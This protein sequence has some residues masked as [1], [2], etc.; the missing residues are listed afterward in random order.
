MDW[1]A[2]L[3][4]DGQLRIDDQQSYKSWLKTLKP[5]CL[6]VTIRNQRK[7]RSLPQ[8]NLHWLRCEYLA[9]YS[10]YSKE[11]IHELLMHACNYHDKLYIDGQEHHVRWTST[12]LSTVQFSELFK[13]QQALA[14]WLSGDGEPLILPDPENYPC[15]HDAKRR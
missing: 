3:S 13:K 5:G 1:L 9:D 10:G 8:N 14:D 2:T 15:S 4:E 6:V 11:A 12:T 7:K